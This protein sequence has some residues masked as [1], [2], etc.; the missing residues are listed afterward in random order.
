MIRSA[1]VL[2]D[3]QAVGQDVRIVGRHRREGSGRPG[4]PGLPRVL[5]CRWLKAEWPGRAFAVKRTGSFAVGVAAAADDRPETK[6][7][8][9]TSQFGVAVAQS[10]PPPVGGLAMVK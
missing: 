6:V 4:E 10:V 2:R 7:L 3:G 8:S 5:Q 9:D 1:V